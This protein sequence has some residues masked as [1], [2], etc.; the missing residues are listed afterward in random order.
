METPKNTYLGYG[1]RCVP[2]YFA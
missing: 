1:E 2:T